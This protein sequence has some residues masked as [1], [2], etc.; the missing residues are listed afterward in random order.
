MWWLILGLLIGAGI[1]W[2]AT[3]HKFKVTWYEWVL[4]ILGV[5]LILFAIQNYSA[6]LF[7]NEP[8][9]GGIM[10][11]M[12]GLPGLVLMAIAA[13][14]SWMQSRKV[15]AKSAPAAEA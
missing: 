12:F 11:W 4:A 5:I 13:V 1:F 14:L 6:S 7:E 9:A 2:L 8:R 15:P 10:L 3:Q